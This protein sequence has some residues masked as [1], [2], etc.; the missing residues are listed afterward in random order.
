MPVEESAVTI[1]DLVASDPSGNE[2]V[3]EGDD[4]LRV[5][6]RVLKT[7]FPGDT[8]DGLTSP[9]IPTANDLNGMDGWYDAWGDILVKDAIYVAS[10]GGINAP[11]NKLF[12]WQSAAPIG[13]TRDRSKDDYMLRTVSSGG[14]GSGGTDSA[15]IIDLSHTHTVAGHSLTSSEMPYHSHNIF[16]NGSSTNTAGTGAESIA[17]YRN[18]NGNED[19]K[20][21]SV[22]G[23]IGVNEPTVGQTSASGGIPVGAHDHGL[24][25]VANTWNSKYL[26]VI[27]CVRDAP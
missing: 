4:H 2:P 5:I 17:S 11:G 7:Q 13:W 25:A 6:K 8:G 18:A 24:T 23:G 22:P 1:S 19:Y 20:A 14:G 21:S 3:S 27:I 15:S 10:G 26:N 16:Y 12:F 9:V